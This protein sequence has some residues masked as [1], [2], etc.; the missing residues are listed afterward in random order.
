MM[1]PMVGAMQQVIGAML[2]PMYEDIRSWPVGGCSLDERDE[3]SQYVPNVFVYLAEEEW[4]QECPAL[5]A[6]VL[7]AATPEWDEWHAERLC[8]EL[9][10][11]TAATLAAP[12][13]EFVGVVIASEEISE[14]RRKGGRVTAKN[15]A[16]KWTPTARDH[17]IIE[18]EGQLGRDATSADVARELHKQGDNHLTSSNV[19]RR[20]KI[21]RSHGW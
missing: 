15:R 19:S 20:R 7:E 8:S 3:R 14:G 2:D 21:L 10:R 6:L 13:S 17:R 16:E 5:L 12:Y 4:V 11:A 18:I 9:A 1:N